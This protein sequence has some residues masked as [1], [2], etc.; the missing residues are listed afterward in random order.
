M[1]GTYLTPCTATPT[2]ELLMKPET[3]IKVGTERLYGSLEVASWTYATYEASIGLQAGKS[4]ALG[5]IAE[6]TWTHQPSFEALEAYNLTDDPLYEVTGEETMVSVTIREFNPDML[7]LA[8]GTGAR[9]DLGNEAIITFGGGCQML[10]RPYSLEF[11]NESCFAP[12]AQNVSLGITGGA[13]VLYD[14]FV[15]SGIEWAMSAKE[16]STIPLE[17]VALPVTERA[18]GN[19][20]GVLYV[21]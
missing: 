7:E 2:A 17:I 4:F 19:R 10:R 3:C 11:M 14:A 6:L 5:I 8:I 20:L 13:I 18:R 12:T 16:G 9:Y 1:A 21:Y 15:Q